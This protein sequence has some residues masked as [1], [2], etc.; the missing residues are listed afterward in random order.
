VQ[1][2]GILQAE[3]RSLAAVMHGMLYLVRDV[4]LR[5]T[6]PRFDVLAAMI[7]YINAF[8]ERFHHP[9]EEAYLFRLL[10]K[11]WSDAGPLIE[12]LQAE[13]RLGAEKISALEQALERCREGGAT[14]FRAFAQAA[15]DYAN[16]QWQHIRTEEDTV[17]PLARAYLTPDDWKV[18]DEAFS[19]HSDPL[20]AVE[21]ER[22][23]ENLFRR[24]VNL[25]PPPLGIG[26]R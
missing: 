5:G 13:H 6:V 20:F 1:A 15:A 17:I 24:I 18:V 14:E 16:L 9:K 19:G 21:T 3:H 22:E 4:R 11:R 26:P 10:A 7:D 23:Y 2:I 12:R 25:A 8:P